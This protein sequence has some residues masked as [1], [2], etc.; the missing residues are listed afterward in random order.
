MRHGTSPAILRE[1]LLET[2]RLHVRTLG[3]EHAH[4]VARFY[5]DNEA[6]LGPWA[7]PRPD[8]FTTSAYWSLALVQAQREL[9]QDRSVHLYL[10]LKGDPRREVIGTVTLSNILRG[11][12]QNANLGYDLDRRYEGKGLMTEAARAVIR[13]A[14]DTLRLHRLLAGYL[15]HNARSAAVLKR[16]GFEI[17][18]RQR[19]F[20]FVD[21]AWRDHVQT[22]LVNPRED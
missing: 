1:V 15:P 16:L 2:E 9:E 7:P 11:P 19:S 6:H 12:L 4:K 10:L 3:P 5:G 14:F 20:L 17:E 13:F 22:G 21:G 18:G 8:G